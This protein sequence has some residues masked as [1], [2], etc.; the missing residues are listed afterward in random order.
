MS[1]A[2]QAIVERLCHAGVIAVLR[3]DS[4]AQLMQVARALLAGGI[5]AIEVTMSTPDAIAG[6]EA[7]ADEHGDQIM[8]GVGTV[9]DPDTARRAIDAG[10]CFVVSPVLVPAVLAV[11]HAACVPCM[12][13]A[14]TPTEILAV[15]NAG[16]DVVKVFPSSVLGPGYFNDILAPLPFLK[17]MPTGGIDAENV[18]Q[19]FKA[20]AVCVG[21]GSVLAPKGEARRG[22]W[23]A[24]TKRA[25]AFVRAVRNARK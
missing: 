23:P 6:I 20:G 4:T 9:L 3:A 19:W 11:A 25:Q 14:F 18:A 22:D 1:T 10:A 24:I 16:A 13:G 17:L 15:H 2:R 7:L 12:P 21:A 8:L 5:S